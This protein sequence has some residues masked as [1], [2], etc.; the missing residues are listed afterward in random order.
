MTPPAPTG[1]PEQT[2]AVSTTN[3]SHGQHQ[4]PEPGATFVGTVR[5]SHPGPRR[6]P[7]RI[8]ARRTLLRAPWINGTN[9]PAAAHPGEAITIDAVQLRGPQGIP[10]RSNQCGSNSVARQCA[11]RRPATRRPLIGHETS[12][13]NRLECPNKPDYG[14]RHRWPIDHIINRAGPQSP[15]SL[16]VPG[17]DS[18]LANRASRPHELV[19]HSLLIATTR[20]RIG[21]LTVVMRLH[22]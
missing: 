17:Q 14:N 10:V 1:P 12:R 13:P 11:S 21:L 22:G 6:S 20:G 7:C 16:L 3:H 18:L 8:R 9:Q 15:R 19:P 5:A 2:S 4:E